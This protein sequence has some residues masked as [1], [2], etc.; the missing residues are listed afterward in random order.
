MTRVGQH[1]LGQLQFGLGLRVG[2]GEIG[3]IRDLVVAG[4][5]AVGVGGLQARDDRPGARRLDALVEPQRRQI[6]A[7]IERFDGR[8]LLLG[9]EYPVVLGSEQIANL[10]GDRPV[11]G[12][13]RS[14]RIRRDGGRRDHAESAGAAGVA[15]GGIAAGLTGPW[16]S[17]GPALGRLDGA[18]VSS[19]AG[20]SSSL[21]RGLR[22]AGRG[23]RRDRGDLCR[24]RGHPA[25]APRRSALQEL[26]PTP[27]SRVCD[28]NGRRSWKC[29]PN[30]YAGPSSA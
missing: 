23:H 1:H 7:L 16:V 14:E 27:C 19:T 11:G 3:K 17:A 15:S 5:E 26:R 6:A 25:N 12:I 2:A 10:L 24:N 28:R 29:S 22:S 8:A 30:L 20:L 13:E 18:V 4:I 9:G 21:Q